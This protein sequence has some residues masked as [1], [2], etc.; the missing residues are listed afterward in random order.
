MQVLLVLAYNNRDIGDI[1]HQFF[2]NSGEGKGLIKI[3]LQNFW[4]S[5]R[6]KNQEA[7]G[8]KQSIKNS[9]LNSPTD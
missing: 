8:V 9:A 6:I 2:Q 3:F 4:I 5:M 1:E 7:H